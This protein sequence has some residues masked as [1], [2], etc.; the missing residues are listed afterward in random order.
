MAKKYFVYERVQ[1]VNAPMI[2]AVINENGVVEGEDADYVRQELARNN[3][4]ANSPEKIFYGDYYWAA[5]ALF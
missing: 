3:Y 4:P 1:G 2:V 5:E